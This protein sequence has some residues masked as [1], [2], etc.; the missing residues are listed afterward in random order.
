MKNVLRNFFHDFPPHRKNILDEGIIKPLPILSFRAW[1]IFGRESFNPVELWRSIKLRG[2][3]M[4]SAE[5]RES[6]KGHKSSSS[7][8][9]I[10]YSCESVFLLL[11]PFFLICCRRW[12]EERLNVNGI[13]MGKAAVRERRLRKEKKSRN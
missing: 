3:R 12:M 9:T 1:A 11:S 5:Q 6:F 8:G 4:K 2:I 10:F 7:G 13:V